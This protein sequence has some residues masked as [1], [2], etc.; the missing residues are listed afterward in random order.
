[1]QAAC[2]AAPAPR[3]ISSL[4][5]LVEFAR[6]WKGIITLGFLLTVAGTAIGLVATY[7]TKPLTDNVLVP[8]QSG[9]QVDWTLAVWYL[10]GLCGAAVLTWLL[11]WLRTYVLAW[12]SERIISDLRTKTYAHLQWLSLEFFGGK[13]TGDLI[14]RIGSD[15]DKICSFLSV[16]LISFASDIL[17]ISMTSI[18]LISIDVQL[19]IAA[20]VPFPIIMWLVHWV[21]TRLRRGFRQANVAARAR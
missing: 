16:N 11:E 13:R 17:M 2:T 19:A 5:R 14:S 6:P 18:V 20:L 1:M 3:A 10:A 4:Y 7:F 21:R 15:T 8:Y 9:H 12:A